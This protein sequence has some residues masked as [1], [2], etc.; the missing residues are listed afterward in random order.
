M[1]KSK[2]GI[3][4]GIQG[5]ENAGCVYCRV[6]RGE[7]IKSNTYILSM[8]EMNWIKLS[9]VKDEHTN[10]LNQPGDFGKF[11]QLERWETLP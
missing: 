6:G 3:L 9:S 5:T 8:E 10:K 11:L 1:L 2:R 4:F 7:G